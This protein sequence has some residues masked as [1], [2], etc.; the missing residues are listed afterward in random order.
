MEKYQCCNNRITILQ[1]SQQNKQHFFQH[2][3]RKP[4]EGE[5]WGARD[6]EITS[7]VLS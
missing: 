4:G 7:V 2:A 1:N 6:K 5:S 3:E